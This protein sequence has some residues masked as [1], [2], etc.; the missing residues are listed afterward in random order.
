MADISRTILAN[1]G[2]QESLLR[3]FTDAYG[4]AKDGG[5]PRLIV[6]WPAA[7][8]NKFQSLLYSRAPQFGY[9]IDRISD[10]AE[11][12]EISWPGP[13][14]FHAHWLTALGKGAENEEGFA[15]NI[16]SA[17]TKIEDFCEKTGAKRVWTAHNLF[18]HNTQFP[19]TMMAIRRKVISTFETIHFLEPAHRAMLEK[20]YED[21]ARNS[22]VARHPHYA[23]SHPNHIEYSEARERVGFEPS[24]KV[25]LF[26]GSIQRYK[27]IAD[28][29]AAFKR[30][31]NEGCGHFRLLIAGFPSDRDHVAELDL[32]TK[33]DERILFVPYKVP[34][35]NI[36]IFFNAADYTIL[37]YAGEQL[38]SGAAILS[39]SFGKPVVAPDLPAFRP[40]EPFGARLYDRN[41]GGL[42]QAIKGL[43]DRQIEIDIESFLS[44]YDV[45]TNSRL[46]FEG[47]EALLD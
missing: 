42:T 29:V 25:L 3:K 15:E 8:M 31:V 13:I 45:S 43:L 20:R 30:A 47:L 37:P 9:A 4:Q 6:C 23:T 11:L 39:L 5:P 24:A 34:D 2:R 41:D 14:F 32:L 38:N 7:R 26:F 12:E 36:Q 17:F 46:F 33:D 19:Q 10:I 1:C 16:E 28:L 18:P 21:T 27:G 40:F 22:F 44:Q 35:E